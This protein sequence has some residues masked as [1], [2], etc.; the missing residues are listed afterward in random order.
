MKFGLIG[1]PLTHSFSKSY[2]EEKF[3]S[4]GL[5]GFTYSNFS[6]GNIENIF[7]ILHS[8]VFGLN[9]TI[10]YKSAVI[11]Y[12]NDIDQ[13]ALKIG[14]VNTL[15]R[16]GLNSWKGFNTDVSGFRLSLQDYMKNSPIPERAIILGTGGAAKA[17]KFSLESI[18]IKSSFVSRESG[19]DYKYEDLTKDVIDSH[20]LIINAT[21]VGTFPKADECPLIPY[22]LLT[23]NHWLFDLVY[24]PTNTLFLTRGAEMGAH[25]KNGL[26]MLHLQAEQAW[27]IWKSYGKF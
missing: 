8:D 18:G 11:Y 26:D 17:V 13:T 4:L 10:P 2:F 5:V 14:A 21:P 12:L 3:H 1:Y 22:H 23:R 7:S 16:T 24:N 6:L 20:L 9:V 19:S 27:I 25:T 15:V